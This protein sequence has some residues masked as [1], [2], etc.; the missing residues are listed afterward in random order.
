MSLRLKHK[1][2]EI[3]GVSYPICFNMSVLER[4]Q[5]GPGAGSIGHLMELPAYSV[6]FDMLKAM[7]DDACEDNPDLPEVPLKRLKKLYS[8]KE[9]GE[10]GVLRMFT[11]AMDVHGIAPGM[12][13]S[14]TDSAKQPETGTEGN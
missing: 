11:A 2:V 10:M 7:L 1:T 13:A 4:L 6:V 5:D 12:D 8:P 14:D 3:D 9:L